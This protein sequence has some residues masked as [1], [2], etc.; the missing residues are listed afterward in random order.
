M[1]NGGSITPFLEEKAQAHQ[2]GENIC[3]YIAVRV[4]KGLKYLHDKDMMHRDIKSDNI[5]V[6]MD[7]DIKLAD[8]GYAI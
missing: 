3:K 7:G 8:F 2:L 1:L 6:S 4:L 5:L